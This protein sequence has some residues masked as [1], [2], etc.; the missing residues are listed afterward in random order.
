MILYKYTGAPFFALT[1][2]RGPAMEGERVGGCSENLD[3]AESAV[4]DRYLVV[5]RN[6]GD[7]GLME[8]GMAG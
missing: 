2:F 8:Q 4:I 5:G 7:R 6:R 3:S 1:A